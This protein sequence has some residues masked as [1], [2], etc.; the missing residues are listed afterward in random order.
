MC[1]NGGFSLSRPQIL[2]IIVLQ[3]KENALKAIGKFCQG[4]NYIN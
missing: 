4:L 2:F 3:N 1:E